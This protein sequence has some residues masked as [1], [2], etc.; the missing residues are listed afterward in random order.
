MFLILWGATKPIE[1]AS[2]LFQMCL[3]LFQNWLRFSC[4]VED[5]VRLQGLFKEVWSSLRPVDFFQISKT[6]F[7]TNLKI[8]R[9]HL[10]LFRT[11]SNMLRFVETF[12]GFPG[13]IILFKDLDRSEKSEKVS[14]QVIILNESGRVPKVIL[15]ESESVRE[16]L[17][18]VMWSL[19]ES[20]TSVARY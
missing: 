8:F 15:N 11:H 16:L 12:Q 6:F 3:R 2:R 13:R 7:Y 20:W 5:S 14:V 10:R 17:E 19:K 9:N 4:P 1:N 18:Y